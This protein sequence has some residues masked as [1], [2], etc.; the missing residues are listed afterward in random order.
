[1]DTGTSERKVGVVVRTARNKVVQKQYQS[2]F[3]FVKTVAQTDPLLQNR[4]R[5]NGIDKSV[6]K[7]LHFCSFLYVLT[8]NQVAII[9][10]INLEKIKERI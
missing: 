8:L 10:K 1:V 4:S 2:G 6:D 7:W 9:T 5:L 3:T